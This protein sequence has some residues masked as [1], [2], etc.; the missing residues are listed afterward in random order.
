M[1]WEKLL[2]AAQKKWL[3]RVGVS[4]LVLAVSISSGGL[5]AI[6]GFPIGAMVYLSLYGHT[7]PGGPHNSGPSASLWG[8][9]IG[10]VVG[11]LIGFIIPIVTFVFFSATDNASTES[12]LAV[13]S[14]SGEQTGSKFQ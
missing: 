14:A 7:A 5:C 10:V 9:I 11:G 4:L 2:M 8:A 1:L 13:D 3:S 12:R 6:L